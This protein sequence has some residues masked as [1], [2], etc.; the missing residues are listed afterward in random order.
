LLPLAAVPALLLFLAAPALLV[1]TAGPARADDLPRTTEFFDEYDANADGRVTPQ[2]FRGSSAIFKLLDKNGDGVI[3]PDDLGLPADYKPDPDARQR[4]R[5]QE[6]GGRRRE[7]GA[8]LRERFLRR[9]EAM[10]TDKD[11]RVSKSEWK[12]PEQAFDQFDRNHDGYLDAK[13][14]PHRPGAGGPAGRRDRPGRDGQVS[15]EALARMKAQFAK[16][17]ANGDG[18]ITSDEFPNARMLAAVDANHDGAVTLEEVLGF[19]RQRAGRAGRGERRDGAPGEGRRRGPGRF[20][21]AML[22]RWDRDQDGKVTRDEFPGREELFKRLDVDGDGVLTPADVEKL[23]ARFEKRRAQG[24]GRAGK[25]PSDRAPSGKAP[26]AKAGGAAKPAA[27][28]GNLIQRQDT[29]GDGRLNRGE[30]RGTA[31]QWRKLDKNG[32]GWITADELG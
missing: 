5:A 27:P 16:L 25:G 11:G 32:D 18:R 31:A 14:A 23:R 6:A 10:D 19:A 30:F 2:E 17:D 15:K 29:D 9:L 13:D 12:G 28:Q 8:R 4:R 22:R 20:N 1:A 21:G 26:G 7:A 24:G 3:T